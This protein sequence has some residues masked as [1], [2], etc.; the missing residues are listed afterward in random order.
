MMPEWKLPHLTSCDKLQTKHRH[1]KIAHEIIFRA[2]HMVNTRNP[3]TPEAEARGLQ[4]QG[5][6]GLQIQTLLK[7]P[8]EKKILSGYVCE[9]HTEQMNFILKFESHPQEISLCICR[10]F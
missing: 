6:P 9:V 4:V 8:K 10:Y 7:T 1:T 5:K 2:P 3:S